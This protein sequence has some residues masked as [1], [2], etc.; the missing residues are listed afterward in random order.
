MDREPS[1]VS[2][3][4]ITPTSLV[5]RAT[6]TV[7]FLHHLQER[8][9]EIVRTQTV[10]QEGLLTEDLQ[11]MAQTADIDGA[12][13]SHW[14]EQMLRRKD[15]HWEEE[16]HQTSM[17]QYM[18]YLLKPLTEEVK[19]RVIAVAEQNPRLTTFF[20]E[21]IDRNPMVGVGALLLYDQASTEQHLGEASPRLSWYKDAIEESFSV[22]QTITAFFDR[23]TA[24]SEGEKEQKLLIPFLRDLKDDLLLNLAEVI[25]LA[26]GMAMHVQG[27]DR[28]AVL[29]SSVPVGVSHEQ[30]NPMKDRILAL[31]QGK[32]H[33]GNG[34]LFSRYSGEVFDYL[35][36]LKKHERFLLVP[37]FT[38]IVDVKR[39]LTF[40]KQFWEQTTSGLSHVVARRDNTDPLDMEIIH[41][42]KAAKVQI[43][44]NPS[45]NAEARICIYGSSNNYGF[46]IRVD[47]EKR[48]QTLSLDIGG[49]DA[50]Q[51]VTFAEFLV[52]LDTLGKPLM[53]YDAVIKPSG[54]IVLPP[55]TY[56]PSIFASELP[57]SQRLRYSSSTGAKAALFL[58]LAMREGEAVGLRKNNNFSYHSREK[59]NTALYYDNF[60]TLSKQFENAL[61][62]CR[63]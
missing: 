22:H 54:K 18:D 1:A 41:L 59:V 8:V 40:Y 43:R 62:R 21:L 12:M 5:N 63:E 3:E 11:I 7:E 49:V 48:Y 26:N 14:V 10:S 19:K 2:V 55:G 34:S 38:S 6:G 16:H 24:A 46:N 28:C 20:S 58:A 52:Q 9:S 30:F 45:S 13:A 33:N 35:R 53:D 25:N 57:A 60:F 4:A 39:F 51:T 29:T 15:S 36:S 44:R 37:V 23:L 42:G 17:R 56:H 61:L 31:R 50:E 27:P 47:Q 32:Q